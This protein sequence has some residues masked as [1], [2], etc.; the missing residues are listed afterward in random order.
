MILN[1]LRLSDI[2]QELLMF[3]TPVGL[4][5]LEERENSERSLRVLLSTLFSFGIMNLNMDKPMLNL[6]QVHINL[7]GTSF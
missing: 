3:R 2:I 5:D 4:F 6:S 1:F 7:T